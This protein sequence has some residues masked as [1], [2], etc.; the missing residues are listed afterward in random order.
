MLVQNT[1]RSCRRQGV[2]LQ[3]VAPWPRPGLHVMEMDRM[4]CAGPRGSF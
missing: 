4:V 3:D 2:L 1:S